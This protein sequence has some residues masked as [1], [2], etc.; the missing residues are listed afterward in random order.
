MVCLV[1]TNED[2]TTYY[3]FEDPFSVSQAM[4]NIPIQIVTLNLMI[5]SD[6]MWCS[7]W[8]H[9]MVFRIDFS[10]NSLCT[11]PT[12][13]T[14]V[15][16]YSLDPSSVGL[17]N[18]K[19]ELAEWCCLSLRSIYRH[20]HVGQWYYIFLLTHWLLWRLV[21]YVRYTNTEEEHVLVWNPLSVS[22]CI[23]IGYK[24]NS[25]SQAQ[26]LTQPV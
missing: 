9:I 12:F 20:S 17:G 4:A 24:T 8:P 19:V 6:H 25:I 22:V 23:N 14:G 1:L 10:V 2:C 18:T 13:I 16:S 5:S 15:N 26:T 3:T 21:I 7:Y 11:R